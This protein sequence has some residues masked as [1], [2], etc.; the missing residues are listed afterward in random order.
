MGFLAE[1]PTELIVG[2]NVGFDVRFI[3]QAAFRCG[4]D[5]GLML[6]RR[7]DTVKVFDARKLGVKN[8]RLSTIAKAL[9]V[10][11]PQKHREMEDCEMLLE[12][13]RRYELNV[14]TRPPSVVDAEGGAEPRR[15]IDEQGVSWAPLWGGAGAHER[16]SDE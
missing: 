15:N 16:Q 8:K 2:H 4:L 7:V 10:T 9:G 5:V 3:E 6:R 1:H 14:E 11:E 13:I 12:C